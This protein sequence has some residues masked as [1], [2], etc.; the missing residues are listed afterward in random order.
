MIDL[1]PLE[2]RKKKGDFRR[3][4]RGY[5]PAMVDDFL[6]LVADRL[7]EV[8]RENM[9]FRERIGRQDQQVADYRER[10]RALTEALVTAQEMREEIRRQTTREAELARQ[11]AEQEAAALRA[12]TAQEAAQ[13]RAAVQQEVRQ[14]RATAQQEVAELRASVRNER[15]REEEALRTLRARQQHFLTSY[16]GFLERELAE[17]GVIVQSMGAGTGSGQRGADAFESPAVNPAP[18][19]FEAP[20][21]A[22]TP[23]APL[24]WLQASP[25]PAGA[26]PAA[27]GAAGGAA[28]AGPVYSGAYEPFEPFETEPLEAFETEAFAT[29]P[30]E[31]EAV[32]D[33]VWGEPELETEA[34]APGEEE[35]DDMFGLAGFD[36]PRAAASSAWDAEFD[37]PVDLVADVGQLDEALAGEEAAAPGGDPLSLAGKTAA[38]AGEPTSPGHEAPAD[39]LELYDVVAA[40][41]ADAG[42]PGP[43]GLGSGP[44]TEWSLGPSADPLD[45]DEF[46]AQLLRNAAAAGYT[47][48]DIELTEELLLDDVLNDDEAAPDPDDDRD[49]WLPTL[50]EDG[51]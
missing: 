1:T 20:S 13:Q 3:A 6:D 37:D 46:E 14:L 9:A 22:R 7:D 10:E 33:D 26:G 44:V 15:E 24:P 23:A 19:S 12:T 32:Q 27:G 43:I 21:A 50:L 49:G 35:P 38:F 41:G 28:G 34:G 31:P 39:E 8:V 48:H 11:A 36:E 29:E 42:V 47:L 4:M 16:R 2:V 45:P 17:L 30:F 18:T 25:E 40:D 5:D 51:K